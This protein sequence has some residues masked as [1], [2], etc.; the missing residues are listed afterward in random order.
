M[1]LDIF[2]YQLENIMLKTNPQLGLL[3]KSSTATYFLI[4]YMLLLSYIRNILRLENWK[5]AHPQNHVLNIQV[6]Q[7]IISTSNQNKRFQEFFF[8]RKFK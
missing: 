8:G 3:Q 1:I 5:D 4:S 6:F 7:K 2:E